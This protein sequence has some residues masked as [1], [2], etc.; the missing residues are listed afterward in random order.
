MQKAA[1][2]IQF[3]LQLLLF[4]VTNDNKEAWLPSVLGTAL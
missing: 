3:M 4:L 1:P 2:R